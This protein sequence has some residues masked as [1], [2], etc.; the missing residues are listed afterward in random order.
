MG[1]LQQGL[2]KERFDLLSPFG[3]GRGIEVYRLLWN[4]PGDDEGHANLTNG[5][6]GLLN[7]CHVSLVLTTID[8]LSA[9]CTSS[10]SY[11]AEP[12]NGTTFS[13]WTSPAT[14]GIIGEEQSTCC[15]R[16][17]F[18]AASTRLLFL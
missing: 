15:M 7:S 10:E 13:A 16:D 9:R 18:C 6:R 4:L 3:E 12:L 2:Y 5:L 14:H 1:I 17:R 11:L 8:W